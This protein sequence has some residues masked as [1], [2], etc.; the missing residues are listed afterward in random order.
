MGEILRSGPAL[1]Q[2]K[3]IQLK[4]TKCLCTVSSGRCVP[5]KESCNRLSFGCASSVGFTALCIYCT[6]ALRNICKNVTSAI[7]L[8]MLQL[9]IVKVEFVKMLLK[10]W[11]V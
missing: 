7:I 8:F 4:I 9:V 11:W 5:Y 1:E 2:G 10:E 6:T 3:M